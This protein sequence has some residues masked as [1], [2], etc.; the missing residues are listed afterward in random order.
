MKSGKIP[1]H[2]VIISPA[3]DTLMVTGAMHTV[4]VLLVTT[5]P[6]QSNAH[7]LLNSFPL[8]MT[9]HKQIGFWTW[10]RAQR[11]SWTKLLLPI[12]AI[13]LLYHSVQTLHNHQLNPQQ[14]SRNI[15]GDTSSK[16]VS[17]IQL[18]QVQ[19]SWDLV[20]QNQSPYRLKYHSR[21]EAP[22]RK[23]KL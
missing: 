14:S 3:L 15:I 2:V 10:T 1:N 9:L 6:P 7:A 13:Q 21:M 17:H 19:N 12:L 4:W 11:F 20:P 16:Q 8:N 22:T 23:I 5:K 18:V